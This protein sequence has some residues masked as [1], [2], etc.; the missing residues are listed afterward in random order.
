MSEYHYLNNQIIYIRN[1][2]DNSYVEFKI[3]EENKK[4]KTKQEYKSYKMTEKDGNKEKEK[5]SKNKNYNSRGSKT[6]KGNI[7]KETKI[8]LINNININNNI[9]NNKKSINNNNRS[10]AKLIKSFNSLFSS[11]K[12]L[13][14][15]ASESKVINPKIKRNNIN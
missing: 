7:S 1:K 2:E 6:Q 9:T 5:K 13:K 15:N 10:R 12:R 8:N 3:I 4:E 14:K 11:R